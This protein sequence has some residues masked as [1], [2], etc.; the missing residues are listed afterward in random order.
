MVTKPRSKIADAPAGSVIA[1]A[2]IPRCSSAVATRTRASANRRLLGPGHTRMIPCASAASTT[3]RGQHP[4]DHV[5]QHHAGDVALPSAQPTGPGFQ[6]SKSRNSRN[7][8]IQPGR[9]RRSPPRR[10][11]AEAERQGGF[12]PRPRR[13]RSSPD[14]SAPP[15]ASLALSPS[16]R[17]QGDRDADQAQDRTAEACSAKKAGRA[18]ATPCAGRGL[19]RPT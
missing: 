15:P 9:A 8:A 3:E 17:W 12:A 19:Q 14:P 2:I 16:G 1:A 18:P 5:V 4:G 10:D 11:R 13:S 6:M 7:A